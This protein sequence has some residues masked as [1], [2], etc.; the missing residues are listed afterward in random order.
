LPLRDAL[1][2]AEMSTAWIVPFLMFAL[3]M[4]MPAAEAPAEQ[5]TA[6]TITAIT[7]FI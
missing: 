6:V 3:V 1:A 7:V 2:L 4:T 5:I